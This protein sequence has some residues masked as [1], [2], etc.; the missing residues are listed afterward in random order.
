MLHIMNVYWMGGTMAKLNEF[1][2]YGYFSLAVLQIPLHLDMRYYS[3]RQEMCVYVYACVCA[4]VRRF[5]LQC[6]IV[7][8][9]RMHRVCVLSGGF[10]GLYMLH[11]TQVEHAPREP[12]SS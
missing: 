8:G 4:C 6:A 5:G 2:Q 9:L 11:S 7:N 1:W 10:I 12:N 3:H